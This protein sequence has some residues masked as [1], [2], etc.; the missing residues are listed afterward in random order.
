MMHGNASYSDIRD[1]LKLMTMSLGRARR[2]HPGVPRRCREGLSL[3]AYVEEEGREVFI[4][5]TDLTRWEISPKQ[6]FEDAIRCAS[7]DE[8]AVFGPLS[9]FMA[10]LRDEGDR[11]LPEGKAFCAPPLYLLSCRSGRYGAAC[12]FYPGLLEELRL[13]LGSDFYILPCSVHELL[14][15]GV[16][17][18]WNAGDL[19]PIVQSVN[20]EEVRREDRLS[21][22]VYYYGEASKGFIR[23]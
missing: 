20:R 23:L 10:D 13:A 14:L 16:G 3:L 21:D 9:A 4:E 12:L 6:L 19:T 8:P 5:R 18:G 17:E 22:R 1:R 2:D 15:I 11:P 7:R